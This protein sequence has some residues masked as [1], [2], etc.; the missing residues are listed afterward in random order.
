MSCNNDLNHYFDLVHQRDWCPINHYGNCGQSCPC[1]RAHI[2]ALDNTFYD[3]PTCTFNIMKKDN[4]HLTLPMCP[5]GIN[6]KSKNKTHLRI[7]AHPCKYGSS[8]YRTSTDHLN[9]FT[10][11]KGHDPFSKR[12]K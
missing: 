6:C 3:C 4:P 10:H 7:F 8:C 1:C 2:N 12:K 9:R 11:P 5:A